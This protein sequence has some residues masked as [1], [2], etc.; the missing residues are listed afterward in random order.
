[1]DN[2]SRISKDKPLREDVR[3]LGNLLG[4]VLIE[5]AGKG[6]F[7][8]EE[9][10]RALSKKNRSAFNPRFDKKMKQIV[11][12]LGTDNL[13]GVIRAFSIYFQLVNIAEQ[14]HRIRRKKY[15]KLHRGN[16]IQRGSFKELALWLKKAGIGQRKLAKILDEISIEL[17]TTAHPTEA[18]RR[19]VLAKIRNI[20]NLLEKREEAGLTHYERR[21]LLAEFKKEITLL[22]QTDEI[23]SFKPSITDEIRNS[24]YYFDE[25]F[26]DSAAEIHEELEDALDGGGKGNFSIPELITFGTW[27]GGDRDGNPLV[28]DAV[29]ERAARFQKDLVLSR[30]RQECRCLL[31]TLSI[32]A[33]IVPASR[34]LMLSIARDGRKMPEVKLATASRN[35][36]EPYRKKLTF[37][38]AKIDNT[39]EKNYGQGKRRIPSSKT[40]ARYEEFLK[41]LNVIRESLIENK[42][43]SA[44]RDSVD[45]LIRK[46]KMFR[47]NL[48]AI[49]VREYSRS[50]NSAVGEIGEIAGVCRKSLYLE[51]G[52]DERVEIL[53]RLFADEGKIENNVSGK[54]TPPSFRIV[55]LFSTI[56]KLREEITTDIINSF[57]IS[58]TDAPSDIL[59]V[60]LLLRVFTFH[61]ERGGKK[62]NGIDVVPLFES[63]ESLRKS[64]LIMKFLWKHPVY[65]KHMRQRGMRQEIMLGYSD[66]NKDGGYLTS[67][68]ELYRAQRNLH[69]ASSRYGIELKLF[70]GRGGTVG[71]GG[72][73]TNAAILALP[74]GLS[75]K[76][77]ITEQGEVISSKYLIKEIA[78]RNF[79]LVLSAM[80]MKMSDTRDKKRYHNKRYESA[81]DALSRNSYNIY[82]NLV[83]EDESF[84]EYFCQASPL[85]EISKLNI[86]SRPSKRKQSAR[87]ED[88]RA[89]PWVFS[90]MQNRHLLPGWYGVGSAFEQ[91]VSLSPAN[92]KLLREM[93]TKWPFFK[94][95]VDNIEMTLS[96]ADMRIAENYM[97]LVKDR[98]TGE[99]IFGKIKDEFALTEKMVLFI[100]GGKNLLEKNPILQRSIVL[101]NPYIDP[102]SYIQICLLRKLREERLSRS[103]RRRFTF[104]TLLTIN[105]ISAGM[106]NTG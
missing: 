47:F 91:F 95:L 6:V 69:T 102:M 33:R 7:D 88:L 4:E 35:T 11:E 100:T 89:I 15:Y 94:T 18:V 79:E 82:R 65:K 74:E 70:H 49:D 32:S 56:K 90:W 73:P 104:M 80:I 39:I 44:A 26:Y 46:V 36:N 38:L 29:T 13:E 9:T 72:G 50:I 85:E 21:K 17:V 24:L 23:R 54:L 43:E 58:N 61:R 97:A 1:M 92:A 10:L 78:L 57:I 62:K 25:I 27:V 45:S 87:I 101:R 55:S 48:S 67:N 20:A 34:K 5:Q 106:R 22:W 84:I 51:S 75:G 96:K 3:F 63:I 8:R 68:W 98:R 77:K 93:Y 83:Y 53:N 64:P 37:M 42:T 28:D 30:Y 81:M 40:Y 41:D 76:I 71:R 19:T 14:Y 16:V 99:R 86:G 105:G 12:A 52:N 66:S 31:D 60:L 103:Q 2:S 59:E